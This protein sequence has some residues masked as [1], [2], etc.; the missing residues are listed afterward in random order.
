[1]A[2]AHP[3]QFNLFDL[4]ALLFA[5]SEPAGPVRPEP[6]PDRLS[7]VLLVNG[8]SAGA[9]MGAAEALAE[10][11]GLP[12]PDFADPFHLPLFDL[13]AEAD[14]SPRDRTALEAAADRLSLPRL[15]VQ[16]QTITGLLL[17]DGLPAVALLLE[18]SEALEALLEHVSGA[19]RDR[20]LGQ[21]CAAA[22]SST[23]LL[24]QTLALLP[25]QRLDQPLDLA[26]R[27]LSLVR[28]RGSDGRNVIT[29]R[30]VL[31]A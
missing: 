27:D 31:S 4:P 2:R 13:G 18:P 3:D 24:G 17:E 23:L 16:A 19:L 20:R 7:L 30:W 1:M 22:D 11:H 26:F 21:F 8:R 12:M 25:E 5:T 28:N 14:L 29:R 10:R 6:V 9:L 15:R